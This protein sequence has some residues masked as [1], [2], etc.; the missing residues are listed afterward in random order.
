MKPQIIGPQ[1]LSIPLGL[2]RLHLPDDFPDDLL[3]AASLR[4]GILSLVAA[5]CWTLGIVLGHLAQAV[6]LPDSDWTRLNA[7]DA[8]GGVS[9]IVSLALF[10][11]TRLGERE[12]RFVLYLGLIYM[13]YTALALGTVFHWDPILPNSSLA[14]EISWI[15]A[16]VLMFAGIV[17]SKP[18]NTF[19]AGIIAVSMNPLN[20]LI[21]RE[22][23]VWILEAPSSA[24]FMLYPDYILVGVAAVISYVM[25]NLG[26]Q[27]RKAR[28][29]GSY[30][31][32]ELLG[33][34]G[35]G[36]VYKA[37]HGMLARPAAIKLIRPEILG[38]VDEQAAQFMIARFRREAEVASK[39]RSQH[40]VELY[41][42]GVTEDGTLYLVMEY[43][44]G[45]DLESLVR[46]NGPLPA[47]RVLFILRQVCES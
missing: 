30:K 2:Q 20:M 45:M 44:D 25:T 14:P 32:G 47:G 4:L 43:L 38:A 8:M 35:M 39:L 41:D 17:P 10:A 1:Q 27:V 9:I 28:E 18:R 6:L 37:T 11:Y 36:E 19:V 23:G 5:A 7:T 42:F 26:Y 40:T 22:R 16:V 15:G 13:V 46:E 12:P 29:I 31:L 34:G 21:A 33:R 24:M 3:R